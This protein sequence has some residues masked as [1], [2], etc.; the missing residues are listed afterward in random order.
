[1]GLGGKGQR[2]SFSPSRPGFK[3]PKK[4][5][6]RSTFTQKSPRF[7]QGEKGDAF[8]GKT[9]SGETPVESKS[10]GGRPGAILKSR[11]GG[12]ERGVNPKEKV[13]KNPQTVVR[14]DTRK[15]KRK[16]T[17]RNLKEKAPPNN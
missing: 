13:W 4:K 11:G 17:V 7:D 1:M 12:R 10:G 5:G 14:G 3:P 6:R 2:G 9:I 8:G 16:R 15:K